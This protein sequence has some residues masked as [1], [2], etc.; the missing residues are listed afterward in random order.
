[1]IDC[2]KF[3]T[4]LG[5][6]GIIYQVEP[7]SLIR[8][9]LP[10]GQ[11]PDDGVAPEVSGCGRFRDKACHPDAGIHKVMASLLRYFEGVPLSV[12]W[13]L[14][15]LNALTA[16]QKAVLKEVY[17]IPFGTLKTYQ[18][19]AR[20][21]ER[22]RACRFVGNALAKNPLPLII[23]CHRVIR[24]DGSIGGF[25][26]GSKIKHRLIQWEASWNERKDVS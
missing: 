24:S 14:L 8:V 17:R 22:P 6:T 11:W 12:E 13:R 25:T 3:E 5:E 9:L 19:I 10:G 4:R 23:P 21:I 7:F 2:V 26:G 1:M 15:D 16:L 18:E 20:A